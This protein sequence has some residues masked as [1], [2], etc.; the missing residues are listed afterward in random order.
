[1]KK[2]FTE[3]MKEGVKYAGYG[4]INKFHEFQFIPAQKGK[5]EGKK[6]LVKEGEGWSVYTTEDNIILHMKVSRK[7]KPSE[8]L[9][10]YLE[11]QDNI[12]R[13]LR[14]YDLSKKLEQK[15]NRKK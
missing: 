6:N 12:L 14:E 5:N 13:V 11:K 3:S 10:A 15:K 4:Y 7:S 2:E 1:M 9:S 8:T